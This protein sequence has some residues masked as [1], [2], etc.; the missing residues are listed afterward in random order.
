MKRR[1][2]LAAS[3]LMGL[4][5]L[6]DNPTSAKLPTQ[7]D[8]DYYEL[9]KYTFSSPQQ[10]DRFDAFVE[11]AYL[12]ALNRAGINPVGVFY[13]LDP[14]ETAY[15][16]L[17]HKSLQS[18][19]TLTARLLADKLF[20]RKGAALLDTPSSDPAYQRIESSLMVAFEKMPQLEI[21]TK[22]PSRILQLRTYES[23]SIK[24][25]QK[26][27]EMFNVGELAIFRKTGL[28]PV[29]FGETLIGPKMP[30]LTY[31]LAFDNMEQRKA[32]WGRFINDPEW[33]KLRSIPEYADKRIV[34]NI[35]NIFFK[36]AACS[37]I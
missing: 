24:A 11:S 30:N 2:F 3:C 27:I 32:A 7:G 13:S 36:P 28:N 8:R 37:Q 16:L 35:T 14:S 25:G 12:P 21:P 5:P 15:L 29:F 1:Q 19:A 26:K 6:A 4:A 33:K 17:P 10:K 9:R 18:V 34:S 20:L 31:M 23:H 22:N